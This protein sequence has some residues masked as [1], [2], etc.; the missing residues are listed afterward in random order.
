[1]KYI[2]NEIILERRVGPL[3]YVYIMLIIVIMLSLIIL[4]ILCYYKTYYV[5][6]GTVLIEDNLYIK[7]YIPIEDVKYITMNNKVIIGRKEYN[8]NILSI[9]NEYFTDNINTYQIIKI[10]VNVDSKYRFNNLTIDLKFL[11]ENKRIIDY[12]LD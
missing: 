9:D 5:A 6:K 1:M 2:Y 12:I 8:Y 10:Y 3:V 11:K 4:C 7:I